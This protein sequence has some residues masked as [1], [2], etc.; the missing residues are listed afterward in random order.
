MRSVP[1]AIKSIAMATQKQV[2]DMTASLTNYVPALRRE[3]THML[4]YSPS[5]KPVAEAIIANPEGMLFL[6]IDIVDRSSETALARMAAK[7]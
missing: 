6:M 7:G 4:F 2:I 5:M 3:V 1:S